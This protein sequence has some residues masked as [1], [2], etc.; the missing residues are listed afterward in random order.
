[1][2]SHLYENITSEDVERL[3]TKF[4]QFGARFS[5]G[6]SGTAEYYGVRIP[7]EYER[8]K[9]QLQLSLEHVPMF[10]TEKQVWGIVDGIVQSCR[11]AQQPNTAVNVASS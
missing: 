2:S 11:A 5:D 10:I 4:T 3:R 8:A 6:D 7:F 1:M 9:G